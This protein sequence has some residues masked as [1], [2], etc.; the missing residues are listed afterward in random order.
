MAKPLP[1]CL[2]FYVGSKGSN[3]GPHSRTDAFQTEL[4]P[5]TDFPGAFNFIFLNPVSIDSFYPLPPLKVDLTVWPRLAWDSLDKL[6]EPQTCSK[7][8]AADSEV[9]AS[10][11]CTTVSGLD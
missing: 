8:R 1:P 7:P 4:S 2:T 10:Q 3:P 11:V 6:D 5:S 9:S